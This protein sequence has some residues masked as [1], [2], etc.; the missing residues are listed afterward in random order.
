MSESAE[1]SR[2][3]LRR[4]RRPAPATGGPAWRPLADRTR[5]GTPPPWC[6]APP[7][8]GF[9]PNKRPFRIWRPFQ[10]FWWSNFKGTPARTQRIVAHRAEAGPQVQD[11][12]VWGSI[13]MLLRHIFFEPCNHLINQKNKYV[14]LLMIKIHSFFANQATNKKHKFAQKQCKPSTNSASTS[15]VWRSA[16]T[17]ISIVDIAWILIK[18]ELSV[19]CCCP[20]LIMDQL[21]GQ[22]CRALAKQRLQRHWQGYTNAKKSPW[23]LN[24]K[25]FFF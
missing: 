12:Q 23:P 7:P 15:Q 17:T 4:G 10:Y 22:K 20:G 13:N 5:P 16:S 6:A 19:Q 2:K 18:T 11:G 8:T 3:A 14:I 24:F 1:R 25:K 9:P 21:K